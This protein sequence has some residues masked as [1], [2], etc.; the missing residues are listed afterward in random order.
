[1]AVLPASANWICDRGVPMWNDDAEAFC[2][3]YA[4]YRVLSA[5]HLAGQWVKAAPAFNLDLCTRF[6]VLPTEFDG[7]SD[8]ILQEYD[9]QQHLRMEY[10]RHH[11]FWSALPFNSA[12]PCS[13]ASFSRCPRAPS[14]P[15]KRPPSPDSCA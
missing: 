5:L 8:A 14:S 10:L 13:P 15:I 3:P 11:G 6:G 1:M 7:T 9:A 12:T 4:P 2:E